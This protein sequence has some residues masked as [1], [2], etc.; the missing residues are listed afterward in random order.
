MGYL[1]W[2][3]P[4]LKGT[5]SD[6]ILYERF[7]KAESWRQEMGQWWLGTG[8]GAVHDVGDMTGYKQDEGHQKCS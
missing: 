2:K 5:C 4:N 7:E 8:A 6:S 1:E 3:K